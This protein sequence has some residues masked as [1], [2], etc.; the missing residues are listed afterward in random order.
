MT[1][2]KQIQ[3]NTRSGFT[4]TEMLC[5]VLLVALA[6]IALV[7]GVSV[8]NRQFQTSIRIS[9]AQQLSTTLETL[10]A[11]ELKY[12]NE[13]V[14]ENGQVKKFYSVTYA[15]S[16]DLT[17]L[18]ILDGNQ[19]I[20]IESNQKYGELALGDDSQYHRILS[21]A[22]Y[23]KQLG[24]KIQSLTFDETKKVFSIQMDI[25]TDALGSLTQETFK[26]RS[27]NEVKVIS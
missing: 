27:L 18:V 12:T 11:N 7:S 8:A 3:M 10:L 25:G 26:V 1:K 16:T 13:I 22:N 24:V 21:H 14:V 2:R 6:S 4:L 23:D 5:T 9:Q 19:N 20:V 15:I 17:E